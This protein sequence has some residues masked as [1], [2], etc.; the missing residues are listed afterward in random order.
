MSV[1]SYIDSYIPAGSATPFTSGDLL[2][3]GG[4]YLTDLPLLGLI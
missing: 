4:I 2:I 1:D 3:R